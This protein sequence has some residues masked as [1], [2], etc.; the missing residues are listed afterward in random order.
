[1][2][3]TDREKIMS[4]NGYEIR[5]ELLKMAKEMLEQDW[6]AKRSVQ[7]QEYSTKVLFSERNGET[8]PPEFFSLTPFPTEE[9]IIKKAK[10][11]NDFVAQK[12]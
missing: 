4:T 6:H 9:Q 8:K 7:E 10:V 11:L 2:H 1:M 12:Q 3:Y 5:L